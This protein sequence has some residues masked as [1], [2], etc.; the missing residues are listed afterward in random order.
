MLWVLLLDLLTFVLQI[1]FTAEIEDSEQRGKARAQLGVGLLVL[2][3]GVVIVSV[4]SDQYLAWWA[5]VPVG[6]G[7]FLLLLLGYLFFADWVVKQNYGD[8]GRRT[9]LRRRP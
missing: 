2:L 7:T 5:F 1:L 4:V 9:K 8:A 3:G 6:I